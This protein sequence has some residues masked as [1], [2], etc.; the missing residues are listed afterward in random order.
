[1]HTEQARRLIKN[2]FFTTQEA[3]VYLHLQ[4]KTLTNMRGSTLGPPFYKFGGAVRYSKPDLDDYAK[5][6]R[7]TPRGRI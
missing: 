7:H 5:N 1:M 3:A 4:A 2:S 6:Q